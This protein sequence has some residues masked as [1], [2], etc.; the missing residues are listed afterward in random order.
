MR[1]FLFAMLGL[2]ALVA[3]LDGRRQQVFRGAAE[4]V[5]V[6]VTVLDRS[7]R[8]VTDLTRDD[9]EVRDNGRVQPITVFDNS[10]QPM[11]LIIMLDVSGS[12]TGNVA[13][14]REATREVLSKIE[15]GD[16][17]RIGMFGKDITFSPTFTS[18]APA[19]LATLPDTIPADAG[20]PMWSGL[21][22]AM[23]EFQGIDGRRVIL[24]L[25]DG[26]DTGP[27][28]WGHDPHFSFPSVLD[29]AQREGFMFYVVAME[30]RGA[31]SVPIPGGS[32]GDHLV[33]N[34]PDPGLPRLARES[35]GGYFEI[36]PRD[37]L[38]AAFARVVDE[39]RR[40]YLLGY[41]PPQ[42][43]GRMHEIDVRV[44]RPDMEPRARKQYLAP[45]S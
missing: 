35:G 29:R 45:R 10:P 37:D 32:L 14:L 24:L 2:A 28:K 21:D 42:L 36:G 27:V 25:S 5:P 44:N 6:H 33:A 40:Q 15:K 12:M 16:L 31:P 9:F 7:G 39:L 17:V 22:R 4:T 34:R 18:D 38:P 30:S 23:T 13:L 20:T 3:S 1:R 19:L 8:L 26:R 43:D 11:R 41:K